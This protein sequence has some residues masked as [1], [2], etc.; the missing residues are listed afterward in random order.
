[1]GLQHSKCS[2]TGPMKS[3]NQL[4]K[5][6]GKAHVNAF[7]SLGKELAIEEEAVVKQTA[8]Q[9]SA[10]T[11]SVDGE[12]PVPLLHAKANRSSHFLQPSSHHQIS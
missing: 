3:F 11:D 9:Q 2:S 5:C 1:M 8:L 4:G 6:P 12:S 10:A 7:Q